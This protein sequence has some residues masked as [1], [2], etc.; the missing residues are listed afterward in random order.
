[1]TSSYPDRGTTADASLP[2][3]PPLAPML[4]RLA[5]ELP[6]GDY[7]YEPKWD[8]FRALCF[9]DAGGVD[10]RSRHDR[11][12]A[13]YFPE[14]VAGLA[15]VSRR[16]FVIDGEIAVVRDGC[17]DFSALM[18]RLHPAATRVERLRHE[19]P[20]IFIGFDLVALGDADLRERP[21]AER[22]ALLVD[23]L[24]DAGE[25]VSLTPATTSAAVAQGWLARYRGAGV[26]GVVAKHQ[27]LRYVPGSRAMI[28]VKPEQTADCVVAGMR[29]GFDGAPLVASLMLGL[30]DERDGPRLEHIGVVSAFTRQQRR[31]MFA[32][33]APLQVRVDAHPWAEG[34]LAQGGPLGRLRGSAG[35]WVPGMSLDWVPLRPE[36]V[37]EVGYDQ[38]DGHRLRHPAR[39]RRWRPD[40]EPASCTVDQLVPASAAVVQLLDA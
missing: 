24:A 32:E 19:A 7:A 15:G 31:T 11:P 18:G 9:V 37:V 13:R 8:G 23:L 34:F 26:D 2:V 38:V 35:R 29:V 36:R 27:D 3:Q 30:Y 6:L 22:R 20:A 39:F 12:L 5:R 25:P 17:F 21:F 33:L 4:A 40:R 16:P 28:K 10:I 14:V 1:V